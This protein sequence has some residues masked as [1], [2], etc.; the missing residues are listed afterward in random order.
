MAAAATHSY[1]D[2]GVGRILANAD[3][4]AIGLKSGF[5]EHVNTG[6]GVG[7]PTPISQRDR[8]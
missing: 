1:H 2:T 4:V 6:I 5:G 8:L 3:D 7:V